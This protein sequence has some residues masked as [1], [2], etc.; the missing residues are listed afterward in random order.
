MTPWLNYH[1]L[2][3]FKTIAEEN[4][5]S[6]AAA[7][8]SLGQPTLSAQLKQFEAQLGS[9]LFERQH[10]KLI[11]TEQG[12]K[13]LQYAQSI[14]KLG[15]EMLEV[16]QDKAVANR[17]HLQIGALDSVPKQVIL[18]IVQQ[19]YKK[20]DCSIS[21]SEGKYDELIRELSSF[22][23]DLCI[24]NFIPNMR[25]IKG[26][27]YRLIARRKISIYGSAKHKHLKK[28]FPHS[29]NGQKFI[30]ST[31]DSK[32]RSDMEHWFATQ[33]ITVDTIAETQD[34]SLKKIMTTEGLGLT[35][36]PD[37][38]VERQIKSGLLYY[39]GDV[40]G[41]FEELYLVAANRK[42]SHPLAQYLIKNISI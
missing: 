5:I 13:A 12:K 1:H 14:F 31:Y 28:G 4:S 23:L 2:F 35:S 10:K 42:L 34:I 25:D 16:L 17:T 29:L 6:K 26:L 20:E 41:V 19:A 7:K 37:Y 30:L 40:S 22:H 39:I 21:L 36:M 27:Q 11:L 8:L 32:N 3:Y 24:M 38:A 15:H 9:E 33:K 18:E